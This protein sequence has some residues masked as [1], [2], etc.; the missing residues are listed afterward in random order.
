MYIIGYGRYL[1]HLK[2]LI[3]FQILQPPLIFTLA[4]EWVIIV[5]KLCSIQVRDGSQNI[6]RG[7]GVFETLDQL[8]NYTQI[9]IL[10]YTPVP[11]LYNMFSYP[12]IMENFSCFISLWFWTVTPYTYF[13]PIC[14][15]SLKVWIKR[16]IYNIYIWFQA[17]VSTLN[18]K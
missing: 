17:K 9:V 7:V 11:S 2:I 3:Y 13:Y 4:N 6:S 16:I 14:P 10:V 1:K 15:L 5:R 8:P 12:P 18:K